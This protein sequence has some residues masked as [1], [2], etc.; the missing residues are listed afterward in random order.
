MMSIE[1][2][3]IPT[4]LS[5]PAQTKFITLLKVYVDNFLGTVQSTDP[6]YLRKVTRSLLHAIEHV[7][8]G[9]DITGSTIGPTVSEKKLIADGTWAIRKGI[10]GWLIVG[11]ARTIELPLDKATKLL[12]TLRW[13]NPVRI[14]RT[15]MRKGTPRPH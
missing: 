1:W 11:I 3:N 14:N 13:Q 12:D 15:L 2:N 8:P 5:D 4:H 10:M 9:P 6:V 7:F